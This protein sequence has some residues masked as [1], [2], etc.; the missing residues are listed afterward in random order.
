MIAT[1]IRFT[2]PAD[3]DWAAIHELLSER[4]ALYAD[5][6]GLISKAFLYQPE[7]RL[8]GGNYVWESREDFERFRASEIFA[9]AKARFGEPA[10]EISHVAAYLDRGRIHTVQGTAR[11]A[12]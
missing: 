8:Y 6:P 7:L 2:L 4:A 3:T 10:I 12:R 9:G 11:S 1:T 5:M